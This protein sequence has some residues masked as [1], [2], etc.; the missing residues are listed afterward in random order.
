MFGGLGRPVELGD[1][2]P[3]WRHAGQPGDLVL[4]AELHQVSGQQIV[5]Q[6][7]VG[8]D[9]EGGGELT[10]AGVETERERRQDHVVRGVLQG[11]S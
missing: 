10:E 6:D 3:E 1:L 8:A 5:Q 4:G 11:R 2:Q 7:H 9:C